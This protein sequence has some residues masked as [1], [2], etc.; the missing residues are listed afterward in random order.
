[1]LCLSALDEVKYLKN[2][3]LQISKSSKEE[4]KSRDIPLAVKQDVK[5]KST[6][7]EVL[8]RL[9]KS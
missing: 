1:M 8:F 4:K 3:V 7:C 5:E 6:F 9:V 2:K